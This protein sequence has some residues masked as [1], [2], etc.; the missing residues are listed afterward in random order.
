MF[1]LPVRSQQGRSGDTNHRGLRDRA[2]GSFRDLSPLS[3][4]TRWQKHSVT[5]QASVVLGGEL[6]RRSFFW[7]SP[8]WCARVLRV[9]TMWGW[10]SQV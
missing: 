6:P 2:F 3:E 4:S 7:E 5:R 10:T 8:L 1:L 9:M